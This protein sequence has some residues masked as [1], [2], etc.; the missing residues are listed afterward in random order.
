MF[1][2]A[3][4]SRLA[5]ADAAAS[6]AAAAPEVQA[7]AAASAGYLAASRAAWQL[8]HTVFVEP[9]DGTG[10]VSGALVDWFRENAAALGLGERGVP[11]RLRA[12]LTDVAAVAR[13]NAESHTL[14]S[15]ESNDESDENRAHASRVSRRTRAGRGGAVSARSSR[16]AGPTP[17]R[18]AA[19]L[20]QLLGRVAH[21]QK[22]SRA[23]R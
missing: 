5:A 8:C 18:T 17:P 15:F 14:A 12:L 20:N 11:E 3:V 16:W 7:A 13:E 23:A 1:A 2:V 9:G 21:G 6:R 22:I 19:H 4:S 10:V